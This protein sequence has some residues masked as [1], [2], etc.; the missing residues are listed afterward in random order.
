[1][2][3]LTVH[4]RSI[5]LLTACMLSAARDAP[6]QPPE[7]DLRTMTLEQ[8][9]DVEVTTV[10][11][12]PGTPAQTPA[13]VTIITQ[14]DIRRSGVTTLAD[15]LR[16][17]P[18]VHV[19]QT[20]A[21]KWGVGIRG[22]T[23]RLSRAMLVLIDG[24]AVYSPLFAGTYWEMQD[25]LLE[26]VE[27]IEVVRGPGGTLWGA[28][29]VTGIIN[30]ITRPADATQGTLLTAGAG[31]EERGFF[32]VRHGGRNGR[33]A[34]RLYGKG[35]TR[36]E[37]A[38]ARPPAFDA[39][40]TAQAGFRT[41]WTSGSGRG[42]TV[43]GDVYGGQAGQR[44]LV[45]TYTPPYQQQVDDD[46]ALAG[47]NVLARWSSRT[48]KGSLV[49]MQAWFD[50]TQRREVAFRETR[51]TLDLDLQTALAP[52]G[53]H[54]VVWGLGYRVSGDRTRS[55]PIREFQPENRTTN[56]FS[57]FVQDQYAWVPSKLEVS[58]G[59][60]FEHNAF[61]G[62]EVQP[63]VRLVWTPDAAQTIVASVTRAVRTPSRVEEDYI[64]GSLLNAQAP[65]FLRLE[66]N[67][68]FE[69][70][71]LIAYESGYRVRLGTRVF[72][73]A[74]AFLNDHE[75]VL[76]A[77]AGAVFRELV[78]GGSRLILP[79]QFVNALHGNSHGIELTGDVRATPWWRWTGS[80]SLLRIQLSSDPGV[81]PG[82]QERRNERGSPQHQGLLRWAIDLP[83]AFELDWMVRAVGALPAV[84]VPAYATSDVRLGWTL[85]ERLTF[86]VVGRNL[87][88]ASHREFT[89]GTAGQVGIQ[90]GVYAGATWM[91]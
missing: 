73:T 76:D 47:G 28:N 90:R 49:T 32:G 39:W 21:N 25:T 65:F 91:F 83:G 26:D 10:M 40:R 77:R 86:E 41:D 88:Q 87:P 70:E 62:V 69:P 54:R 8:L 44:V 4:A 82:G 34:W 61:S 59:A 9:L 56:L 50:R 29:A 67:D 30:I 80:Y 64:T 27:R 2:I 57:A 71:Q 66:P 79:V 33:L 78:D 85:R 3:R 58:A 75:R 42:L 38:A 84:N 15:A 24:R 23:D 45:T 55:V 31:T 7:G 74:S 53:R 5:L 14:E 1:M 12:V 16:L 48:R 20:D 13:A 68:D 6:A 22:F 11:R 17:A 51:N 46:V 43:Q 81:P 60:R 37:A 36:D 63:S 19:A 18:G 35:F 89:G 72:L 52:I